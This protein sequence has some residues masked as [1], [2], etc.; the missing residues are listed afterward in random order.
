MVAIIIRAN[1][2]GQFDKQGTANRRISASANAEQAVQA[3][4]KFA[5]GRAYRVELYQDGI[6]PTN[7]GDSTIRPCVTIEQMAL[8][9]AETRKWETP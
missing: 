3:A 7:S 9:F 1:E 6:V 5:E 8:P 2:V 4:I